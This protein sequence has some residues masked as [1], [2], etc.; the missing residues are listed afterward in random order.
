MVVQAH[1]GAPRMTFARLALPKGLAL[2]CSS[3][4]HPAARLRVDGRRR[5]VSLSTKAIRITRPGSGGVRFRVRTSPGRMKIS[6]A[7]LRKLRRSGKLVLS[8]KVAEAGSPA[9][10]HQ[11][12]ASVRR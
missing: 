12:H 9:L 8:G 1:S 6:G 2:K 11:V 10:A 3:R 7:L 4:K 5:R